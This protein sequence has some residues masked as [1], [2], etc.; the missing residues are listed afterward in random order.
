MWREATVWAS[1]ESPQVDDLE[2]R[3]RQSA[4]GVAVAVDAKAVERAL[5]GSVDQLGLVLLRVVVHDL[6]A[7]ECA[8]TVADDAPLLRQ[9]LRAA[10]KCEASR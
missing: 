9:A 8:V 5:I 2:V 7:E 1:T 3:L 10:E 4:H 6:S